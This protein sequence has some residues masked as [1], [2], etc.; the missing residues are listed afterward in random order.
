MAG[1]AAGSI[2]TGIVAAVAGV[3][4]LNACSPSEP[5]EAAVRRYMKG[6]DFYLK[7]QL[8]AAE[9]IFHRLAASYS[10]FYQSRFMDAKALYLLRRSGEAERTLEELVKDYPRYHEA[11]IW[12]ARIEVER[13]EF[14]LADKRLSELLSYDSLDPR[15]LYLMA[16][17]RRRRGN[18]NE[19]IT[20]LKKAASY[21]EE[22]ARVH[23]DLGR[24]YYRFGLDVKARTEFD[25]VLFLLP[26]QSPLRRPVNV[27]LSQI[28]TKE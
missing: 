27:L 12:L 15:L 22:M 26:S 24:L 13:G 7:G 18:L 19:S 11:G 3:L 9:A 2:S 20:Y 5:P 17:V 23:L 1:I 4:L 8:E 21:E 25:R 10:A 6:E 28:S 16:E 14:D